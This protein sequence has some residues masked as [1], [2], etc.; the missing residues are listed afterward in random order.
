M[1]ANS[2]KDYRGTTPSLHSILPAQAALEEHKDRQARER[3]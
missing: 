2:A 3:E 1:G